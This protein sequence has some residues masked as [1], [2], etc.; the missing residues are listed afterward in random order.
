MIIYKTDIS[1]YYLP[2]F[3]VVQFRLVLW[4]CLCDIQAGTVH[5]GNQILAGERKAICVV[6]Y[7][8]AAVN[9]RTHL[10]MSQADV[11]L[12]TA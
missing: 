12:A 5:R 9:Y 7:W 2:Q 4:T 1:T 3:C 6:V 10:P 11:A 8:H